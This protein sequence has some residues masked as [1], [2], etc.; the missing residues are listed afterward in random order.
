VQLTMIIEGICGAVFAF[1]VTAD[2]VP[3]S[4]I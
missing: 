4:T 1:D 3:H 2:A